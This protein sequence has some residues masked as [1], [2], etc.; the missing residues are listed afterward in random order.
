MN[1][2]YSHRNSNEQIHIFAYLILVSLFFLPGSMLLAASEY[3]AA[4][5]KQ[6]FS[7]YQDKDNTYQPRTEH[8]N[9][10]GTPKYINRLILE[11]S[12]YLLQHAHNP[13]NWYAWGAEA[14]LRPK[15]RISLFFYL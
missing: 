2:N 12:P 6:F 13:V 8:F 15:R 10:D 9:T 4:E 14:L 5:K 1:K 7:A 11:E 3:S